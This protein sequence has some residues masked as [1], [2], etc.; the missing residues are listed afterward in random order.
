MHTF[1]FF[2]I[3][4]YECINNNLKLFKIYFASSFLWHPKREVKLNF[5]HA[6]YV[7][8]SFIIITY[9]WNSFILTKALFKVLDNVNIK[10]YDDHQSILFLSVVFGAL[11]FSFLFCLAATK[12]KID[13][14]WGPHKRGRHKTKKSPFARRQTN[15]NFFFFFSFFFRLNC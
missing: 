7:R 6:S 13:E 8:V 12:R 14:F 9:K 10:D 4:L 5:K 11:F 15:T 1:V 3:F 2:Y